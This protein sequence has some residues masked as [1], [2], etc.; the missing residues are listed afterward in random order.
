MESPGG[1][2]DAGTHETGGFSAK[3]ASA[4][5]ARPPGRQGARAGSAPSGPRGPPRRRGWGPG[6]SG[7]LPS[8]PPPGVGLL[9]CLRGGPRS[10]RGAPGVPA[11][12]SPLHGQEPGTRRLFE[13]SGSRSRSLRGRRSSRDRGVTLLPPPPRPPPP[14][15][16]AWRSWILPSRR[17]RRGIA[18][19]AAR[20]RAARRQ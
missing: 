13:G 8:P 6:T 17:K 10:G 4:G 11:C 20:A 18:V 3:N 12:G 14:A 9:R 15:S 1:E 19:Q 7:A 5:T 16:P 2:A